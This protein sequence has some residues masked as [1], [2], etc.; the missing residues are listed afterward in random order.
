MQDLIIEYKNA[1]KDVK[2]TY[3]QLS[4]VAD[5]LLTAEQKS[6]KKDHW[7]HD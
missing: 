4:Q 1:L 7:W 3:R 2:K 5:S 6:D